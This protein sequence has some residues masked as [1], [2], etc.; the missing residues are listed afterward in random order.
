MRKFS[1]DDYEELYGRLMH[2]VNNVSLL[3]ESGTIRGNRRLV[4][5]KQR[6][7][8]VLTIL[9]KIIEDMLDPR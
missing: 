2:E 4:W 1:D 7:K 5:K 3:V 8:E 6:A 9:K